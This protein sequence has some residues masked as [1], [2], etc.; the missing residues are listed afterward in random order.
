MR[1]LQMQ[2]PTA[3]LRPRSQLSLRH[4]EVGR[5]VHVM[6]NADDLRLAHAREVEKVR[7]DASGPMIAFMSSFFIAP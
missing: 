1:S 5:A 4:A 3:R 7:F 6:Q 2:A